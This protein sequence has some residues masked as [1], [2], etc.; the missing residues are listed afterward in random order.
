MG[1]SF[2][3]PTIP[4]CPKLYGVANSAAVSGTEYFTV[5]ANIEGVEQKEACCG[6][7]CDSSD[8][9]MDEWYMR[10]DPDI[11]PN[12][13]CIPNANG[14]PDYADY[15]EAC[16]LTGNPKVYYKAFPN[17]GSPI[18]GS[19]DMAYNSD[20]G[21]FEANVPLTGL[22]E[23]DEMTY[24]I[25][26]SDNRGNVIAQ[27]PD[28]STVPCTSV[29]SW[30]TDYE[31]PPLNNCDFMNGYD[32]CANNQEGSPVCGSD[33]SAN[34]PAGDT[35]GEP[36]SNGNAPTVSGIDLVD[37]LGI[38]AG[39][40]KGFGDLPG[41]EVVCSRIGLMDAPPNTSEGVIDAYVMIFFNPDIP[42]PNPANIHME[43]AFAITY[44]PEAAGAD[45][46]LV[47]VL[48]DG[49]CVT[50]P[51]TADILGCKI[52][53]GSDSENRLKI[54]YNNG[55]L[56]FIAQNDLGGRTMVGNTNKETTM[57]FGTGAI[58]LSGGTPFWLTDLSV[59]LTMQKNNKSAT[60]GPPGNPAAP[61]PKSISCQVG[62]SGD[63]TTCPQSTTQPASNECV[64]TI[65]PS[66]DKSFT[67]YYNVYHGMTSS[68]SDATLVAE[69]S[70]ATNFPENGSS[71]YTKSY[72]VTTLDGKPHYFFLSSVN[73]GGGD[74]LETEQSNWQKTSCTVEDWVPP[75]AP[76]AFTCSTPDGF[77]SRCK[78]RVDRGYQHRPVTVRFLPEAGQYS[79]EPDWRYSCPELY[80]FRRGA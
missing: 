37:I 69:L 27:V 56:I 58:Q 17:V 45:P 14:H 36:D 78:C 52:F 44:A 42:D 41:V 12:P 73:A 29:S 54:K 76:T 16:K 7:N 21:K 11:E 43:N 72:S 63:A 65:T 68:A 31:T 50:D 74:P 24:Y 10:P 20:T 51:D 9:D 59:G 28:P 75:S 2:D 4:Q 33:Y 66:P 6:S 22:Q 79:S 71:N 67:T 1:F 70:G 48:W 32:L 26:A 13:T 18:S 15:D 46:N 60:V 49:D 55:D 62:G 39:A 34:D 25:V 61:N 3:I 19:V 38:S 80:R 35:C 5:S 77:E 23:N 47:K 30:S 8:C 57:I 40:G 53:I 64:M